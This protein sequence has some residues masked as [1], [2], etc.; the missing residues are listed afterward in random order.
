VHHGLALEDRLPLS[1]GLAACLV[2][3][4]LIGAATRRVDWVVLL[5]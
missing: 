5:I 4:A 2:A 3:M 1:A